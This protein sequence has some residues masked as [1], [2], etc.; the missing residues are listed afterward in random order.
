MGNELVRKLSHHALCSCS[1]RGHWRGCGVWHLRRQCAQ[2]VSRS[3]GTSGRPDCDGIWRGLG[4][5]DHPYRQHDSVARIRAALSLFWVGARHH[6]RAAVA[7]LGSTAPG[8]QGTGDARCSR[9]RSIDT[10][11]IR[12]A[13]DAADISIREATS[14]DEHSIKEFCATRLAKFKVPQRIYFLEE[15]PKGATGK[16]QRI[17]LAAR[18]GLM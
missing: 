12:A 16:L 5:H 3:A 18:L 2:M 13:G 7:V 6:R 9:L 14:A 8:P 4:A 17:G 11:S 1:G 10:P 15:I